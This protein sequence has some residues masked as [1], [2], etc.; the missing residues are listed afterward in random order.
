M[1]KSLIAAC[2]STPRSPIDLSS[3]SAVT[4]APCSA[5]WAVQDYAHLNLGAHRAWPCGS[6]RSRRV[7]AFCRPE[8]QSVR[9]ETEQFKAFDYDEFVARD[10]ASLDL[11]WLRDRVLRLL[12]TYP[13][14]TS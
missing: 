1:S 8:N 12:S 10:K 11:F 13:R 3:R 2:P 9:E 6:S 14:R 4:S 7:F 5:G